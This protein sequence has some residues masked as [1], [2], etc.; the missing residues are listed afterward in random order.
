[1][2]NFSSFQDTLPD[3]NNSIGNAGQPTGSTGPGYASVEL[4][5]ENKNLRSRTNS[6]RLISRSIAYHTWKVNIGYNP[7]TRSEFENIY[8]FLIHRRGSMT[9][10]FVS[11]PQY[12]LA[13]NA[14]FVVHQGTGSTP[15]EAAGTTFAGATSA[16]IGRSGYSSAT[17]GT[18]EPG[19]L[20]NINGANSN[21]KKAYMVTKVET[22]DDYLTGS[23]PASNAQ[24]RVHFTPGL[25]KT[26]TTGDDF[27]FYNPKIKVIAN[28]IQSYSLGV[29]GL[30]QFGLQL[31]EVQ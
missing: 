16:L 22:Y 26:I 1:M 10:F 25:A 4:T 23:R 31:E 24:I 29:N 20:F 13:Q 18:P 19:D 21:H 6:G 8:N 17:N 11:L 5:S 14:N 30:Y 3:P 2:A 9:P 7:M 27:V 12:R 15:L 28:D